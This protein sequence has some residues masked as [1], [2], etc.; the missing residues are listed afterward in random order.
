MNENLS[1]KLKMLP[2]LWRHSMNKFYMYNGS[3]FGSKRNWFTTLFL[4]GASFSAGAYG[5]PTTDDRPTNDRPLFLEELSWK[6][7]KRPYLHNGAR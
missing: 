2:L 1:D 7:F 4:Q 5:R 3:F 6:N